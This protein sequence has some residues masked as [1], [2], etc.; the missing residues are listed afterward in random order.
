MERVRRLAVVVLVAALGAGGLS[1]CRSHPDV[2][3]YVGGEKITTAQVEEVYADARTKLNEAAAQFRREQQG[4][5]TPTA[6][7]TEPQLPINRRDIVA[8]LVGR[9]VLRRL[10][11]E[12]NVKPAPPSAEDVA[13]LFSLP[14]DTRFVRDHV[15]F[16][17]Y[18]DALSKTAGDTP[19]T[20]A[21][22]A[23]ILRRIQ[24]AGGLPA[25]MKLADFR[26]N[27]SDADN[28]VLARNIALRNLLRERV[29]EVDTRINPRYG[30]AEVP[31]VTYRSGEGE[32][33]PLIVVAFDGTP[34]G[35]AVVE[36]G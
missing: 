32:P 28:A 30:R 22:L 13:Q 25:D 34:G 5:A 16:R 6:S 24:R 35:P 11:Q 10:A 26:A 33:V 19:P 4:G 29:A 14:P 1:A 21:D 9:E 17:G 7:P 18:L 23:E 15:E 2:A 31:L 20:D 36:A 27:L 3:A 8:T 12:R